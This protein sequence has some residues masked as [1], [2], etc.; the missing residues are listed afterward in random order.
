MCRAGPLVWKVVFRDNPI[1]IV[2]PIGHVPAKEAARNATIC[3]G[4][5]WP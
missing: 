5:T 2:G 1:S 4:D 3:R